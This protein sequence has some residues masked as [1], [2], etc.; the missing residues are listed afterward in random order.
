MKKMTRPTFQK[1]FQQ[2]LFIYI[3]LATLAGMLTWIHLFDID[4]PNTTKQLEL[5]SQ[6][7]QHTSTS[8]YQYR[9]LQPW[10]VSGL[11]S[12]NLLP[13][14]YE[15]LIGYAGIRFA[16][17]FI[18]LLATWYFSRRYM[19]KNIA[20]AGSLILAAI[21]PYTYAHYFY[22]PTSIL[23]LAAF[24]LGFVLIVKDK[25]QWLA[26]LIFFSTFNRETMVFLAA[27]YVLFHWKTDKTGLSQ[28]LARSFVLLLAWLMPFWGL[29]LLWPASET[30]GSIIDYIRYNITTK[31]L[32]IEVGLIVLP[33]LMIAVVYPKSKPK[34]MLRC[35]LLVPAWLVICFLFSQMNET[36]YYLPMLIPAIPLILLTIS[37]IA[38]EPLSTRTI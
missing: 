11:V 31:F 19:H 12:L 9:I 4:W 3:L 28:L 29:R 1:F 10:L 27:Y 5:H 16:C 21:I 22:Q 6:I 25:W 17:I 14:K 18:T 8:P 13:T 2:D 36:R 26:V 37:R 24:A 32:A 35:M 34:E 30:V 33:F 20:L 15:F 23:E 38:N 7:L